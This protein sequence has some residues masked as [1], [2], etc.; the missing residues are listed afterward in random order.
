MNNRKKG[1]ILAIFMIMCFFCPSPL[2]AAAAEERMGRPDIGNVAEPESVT[3]G[4]EL[5]EWLEAHKNTGGAVKLAGNVVLDGFYCY[6]P[7]A[8]NT[9]A[10]LVDTDCYTITVAGEIEFWSVC[11]LIFMGA[12]D[13]FHVADGGLLT[14]SNVIVES[15]QYALWQEE[16]AG[17]IVDNC[18]V[19]GDIHYADM[20]FVLN[21]DAG[22][23]C[24]IVEKGQTAA[25]VLAPEI[26]CTVNFQGQVRYH[27]AVAVSWLLEGTEKQQ[28]QRL[29][30][31]ARVSF[32]YAAAKE[33]LYCTVAYHDYPLTFTLVR[34]AMSDNSYLFRGEYTKPEESLPI[35]VI[36]EYSFDGADWKEYQKMNV[37]HV[38]DAFFI[39][40]LKN[41]WDTV[42]HPFVYIRLQWQDGGTPHFSNVLR[43]AA[44]NLGHAE[45]Q[46]GSRG[47]GTSIVNPPDKPQEHP[48][49]E[50]QSCQAKELQESFS[51]EPQR[52][53]AKE[54]QEHP[55]G[56][57]QNQ[58]S[59]GAQGRP[60]GGQQKHLGDEPQTSFAGK[61]QDSLEG[62]FWESGN[63]VAA[64]PDNRTDPHSDTG[65][66]AETGPSAAEPAEYADEVLEV[67]SESDTSSESAVL[68]S[69]NGE[70][71]SYYP[72]L[73]VGKTPVQTSRGDRLMLAAAGFAALSVIG[74]M[75]AFC[76][77]AGIFRKLVRSASQKRME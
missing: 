34:A 31:L 57:L 62:V 14:L 18:Q 61:P 70:D 11:N 7:N 55:S 41:E 58:L 26:K 21:Q 42:K 36:S 32:D 47:G 9:P 15:G 56:E 66:S 51:G 17:L 53:Q 74:G 77:H 19:S 30:F 33:P 35:T 43:Y 46:G 27:E 45:D 38:A 22:S 54:L 48:S 2:T 20:P 64:E 29:R 67:G 3:T 72:S 60:S 52:Y 8:A 40:I 16:G 1:Y 5:M 12:K 76:F 24:V 75:A 65:K 44:G 59:E 37:S 10:V 63:P 4:A 50:P 13:I 23:A 68:P 69:V 39:G 25:D 49:D 28:E 71:R 73:Q 6:C